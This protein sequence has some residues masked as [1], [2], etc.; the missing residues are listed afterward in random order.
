MELPAAVHAL[1]SSE[2]RLKEYAKEYLEGTPLSVLEIRIKGTLGK[3]VA[4]Q[5]SEAFRGPITASGLPTE[6]EGSL[7]QKHGLLGDESW[8]APQIVTRSADLARP[9]YESSVAHEYLDTEE[10]LKAKVVLLASLVRK[11]KRP[12][13]YAGAGLSTASGVG[14]YATRTGA[15]SVLAK[16]Q[17]ESGQRKGFILPCSARPNLGHSVVSAMAQSGL[18][19]RVVQQNHDGL[20]QKAGTPQRFMNEIHGSWF[21]PSNPV[22]KMSESLRGDLYEDTCVVDSEADLVLVLGSS[23]AGMNTD[24]IVHSCAKRSLYSGRFKDCLGTVIVSLQ[25]T[26]QDAESSLRIFATIDAVMGLLVKELGLTVPD[27]DRYVHTLDKVGDVFSVPYD[28]NGRLVGGHGAAKRV[29]DMREGSQLIVTI[30]ADQGQKATVLGKHPEGHYKISVRRSEDKGGV[31]SIRYLGLW[32]VDAAI[33][34]EV[35]RIPLVT[36]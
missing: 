21:D 25:R 29:L 13:I 10:V 15:D 9:G 28:N 18:L 11:A 20:L 1:V 23:L 31:D 24:R 32:W 33:S 30:G 35:P 34:G 12:V 4:D 2:A 8:A 36:A 27:L 17:D 22:V 7:G 5:F 6:L 14:D 19:W 3:S 16:Q 26:P